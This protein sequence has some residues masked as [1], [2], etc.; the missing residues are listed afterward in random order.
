MKVVWRFSVFFT[1]LFLLMSA[2]VSNSSSLRSTIEAQSTRI[3]ELNPETQVIGPAD[4]TSSENQNKLSPTTETTIQVAQTFEALK[5][6]YASALTQ[7]PEPTLATICAAEEWKVIPVTV[8]SVDPRYLL[9]AP[10]AGYKYILVSF[11]V[12]NNSPYWGEID[13]FNPWTATIVTEGG[14]SYPTTELPQ[15]QGMPYCEENFPN[16]PRY[17]GMNRYYL[18][19]GGILPPGFSIRGNFHEMNHDYQLFHTAFEVAESQNHFT[20][21]F[22]RIHV[23]CFPPGKDPSGENEFV[24][25][26]AL[27]LDQ[28]AQEITFPE[29]RPDSQNPSITDTFDVPGIGTFQLQDISR[30]QDGNVISMRFLFINASA[31][32]EIYGPF[33]GSRGFLIGDDG[34]I[35]HFEYDSAYSAGPGLSTEFY[36]KVWVGTKASN[37]RLVWIEGGQWPNNDVTY[38]MVFDLPDGY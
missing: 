21:I 35:R 15:T 13:S 25:N 28:D 36:A 26:Y 1:L 12:V 11:A 16:S 10:H 32:Y 7:T 34:I 24:M 33:S 37:F 22:P 17:C 8:Y 23:R 30:E 5:T 2:C 20:I 38:K 9:V 4:A 19:S 29:Y 27:D 31:G 14:F 18:P 3:A 6:Q